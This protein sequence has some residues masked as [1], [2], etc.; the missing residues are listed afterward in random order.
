MGQAV[1]AA[2]AALARI[3]IADARTDARL[4]AQHVLGV[5]RAG[6]L[7]A[8]DRRLTQPDLAV[9]A[10]LVTRRA[11][12]EPVSRILQ[13]RE[14]WSLTFDLSPA[15]LDPRPDSET[16]VEAALELMPQRQARVEMLDIG[17]GTGCLL[18]AILSER[19]QARGTGV[20][21]SFMAAA[22]ARRNA[23]RLGLADR[24]AFVVGD[25]A[26]T[27]CA[28]RFDVVVAN[29]P[30]VADGD[31]ARLAPE[32]TDF[33]PRL[34]LAGGT[35]G[36][37]AHRALAAALPAVVRPG[38]HAV[39]EIGAGQAAAV[40]ALLSACGAEPVGERRDLAGTVRCLIVRFGNAKKKLES[41]RVAGRVNHSKPG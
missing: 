32:V 5:D 1:A 7:A 3:G 14:F 15:T 17:T 13:Q 11:G 23:V 27:F 38:G 28:D 39:L 10:R 16:V 37:D 18:L 9:Y 12:R 33:D 35:D 26:T 20:D 25:W 21:R 2:A 40:A 8:R 4:L 19:P 36:L 30:Y 41:P 24:A 6:L 31:L 22:T 34:A 29:P